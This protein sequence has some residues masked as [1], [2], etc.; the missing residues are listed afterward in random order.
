MPYADPERNSACKAK[1]ER[2]NRDHVNALHR[3]GYRRNRD[4]RLAD[5]KARNDANPERRRRTV[6]KSRYKTTDAKID[7]LIERDGGKCAVCGDE[8]WHLDHCHETNELRGLLCG[9]CNRALGMLRE[10][11]ERITRLAEYAR[12]RCRGG[13]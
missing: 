1:W 8:R 7:A 2:D 10:S 12:D 4:K 11:P 9:N 13:E 6:M 3:D 5:N